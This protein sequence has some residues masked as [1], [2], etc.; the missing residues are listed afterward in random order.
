[1]TK[2]NNKNFPF[3]IN[4]NSLLNYIK[5]IKILNYILN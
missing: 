5:F 3:F 2:I 1:M 4:Q